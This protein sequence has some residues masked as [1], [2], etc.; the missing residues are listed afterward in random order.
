MK[1]QDKILACYRAVN[2]CMKQE[3]TVRASCF[4]HPTGQS[5]EAMLIR[6]LMGCGMWDSLSVG[7]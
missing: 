1:S 7:R 5:G 4:D 2:R 6:L 3:M